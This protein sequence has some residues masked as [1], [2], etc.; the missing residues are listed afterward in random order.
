MRI[1]KFF[2]KRIITIFANT[3]LQMIIAYHAVKKY[4]NQPYPL[5][6]SKWKLIISIS[7]FI[8]LFMLI[9]QPFGLSS[10][11]ETYKAIFCIGYGFVTLIILIFD[12]YI[13]QHIFK[14]WFDY[15]RWT[16]WK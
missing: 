3:K 9:F 12:L 2:V 6:G 4:L 5:S 14:T 8:G 13:I 15:R 11:N 1:G 7:L 16:V 10:S